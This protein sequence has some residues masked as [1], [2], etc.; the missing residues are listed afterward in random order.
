MERVSLRALARG[1]AMN[2][3]QILW[4]EIF[5]LTRKQVNMRGAMSFNFCFENESLMQIIGL[6]SMI[7]HQLNVLEGDYENL[8]LGISSSNSKALLAHGTSGDGNEHSKCIYLCSPLFQESV[9]H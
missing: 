1:D 4:N 7:W 3:K 9:N 6:H 5:L 8:L 2:A